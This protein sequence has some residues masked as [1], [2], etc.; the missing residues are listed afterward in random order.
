V[1]SLSIV[2]SECTTGLLVFKNLRLEIVVI[3]G[4]VSLKPFFLYC[5][6]RS[7]KKSLRAYSSAATDSG[8][9]YSDASMK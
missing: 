1:Q 2:Y 5:D 6:H 9:K 8:Q 7:Q 4:I 3:G